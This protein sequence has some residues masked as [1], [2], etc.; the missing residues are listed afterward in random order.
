MY[1]YTDAFV[2][3]CIGFNIR[4]YGRFEEPVEGLFSLPKES[5][6]FSQKVIFARVKHRE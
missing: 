6:Q 5:K 3:V 2:C 4:K 1:V